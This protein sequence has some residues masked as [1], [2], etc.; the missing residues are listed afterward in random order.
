MPYLVEHAA[1]P[2]HAAL[3][4][5]VL[6]AALPDHL[7]NALYFWGDGQLPAEFSGEVLQQGQK[8]AVVIKRVPLA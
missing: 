2:H 3:G 6:A 7:D 5:H 8:P 1:V 4:V